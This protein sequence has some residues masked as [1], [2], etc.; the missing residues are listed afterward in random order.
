MTE[1]EKSQGFSLKNRTVCLI[2]C[3]GL[4]CNV[5]VHLAGEGAGK[6]FL[7]DFDTVTESNLNRQFLYREEDIGKSKCKVAAEKLSAY[8]ADCEFFAVER[9]IQSKDDLLF[10]KESHIIILAVD[11]SAV[12]TVAESFAT[13]N[14]IP[15]VTGGIDGFYGMA[16]L[17]I[18]HKSPCTFCAGLRENSRAK[19]NISS[20]AGIIGSAEAALATEYLLT[21]NDNLAGNLLIFDEG[22]FHTLK[23]SPSEECSM[24]NQ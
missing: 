9:K 22:S 15:L 10:A 21:G 16:Y 23:I 13:E 4:G 19:H 1:K 11:N 24:C 17:Y 6:L 7:C 5:A 2:G 18:P 14:E 12:R 3:G 20:V 8:S